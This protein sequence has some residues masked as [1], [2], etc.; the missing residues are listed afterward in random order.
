MTLPPWFCSLVLAGVLGVLAL[1]ALITT[2][3]SSRLLGRVQRRSSPI[4]FIFTLTSAVH[5]RAEGA[6]CRERTRLG[7]TVVLGTPY[8]GEGE[9]MTT[10]KN[11][12][13]GDTEAAGA[14]GSSRKVK[15]LDKKTYK[16]ELARL[17]LELVKLQSGFGHRGSRSW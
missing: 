5:V 13:K 11:S 1:K 12:K 10:K 6:V 15:T 8:K 7:Y 3:D 4:C 14:N 16:A 2:G 17:Q 9:K